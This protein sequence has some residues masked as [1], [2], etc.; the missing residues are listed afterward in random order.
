MSVQFLESVF[1]DSL[2]HPNF[3]N[4]RVLT[5]TD[6]RDEQYASVRRGRYL[7]QAAGE[8]VVYGLN[9]T[10]ATGGNALEITGGLAVCRSGDT[11]HLSGESTTVELVVQEP[12][13]AGTDSPFMVCAPAGSVTLTGVVSTGFYVLA[14]TSASRLSPEL[15]A[16]SGLNGGAPACINRYEEIGVQFK[17]IPLTNADLIAPIGATS[18]LRRSQLAHS[19]FGTNELAAVYTDPLNTPAQYG[20]IDRLRDSRLTDCDVPLAVFQF[21]AGAVDFVDVWSARR[22]CLPGMRPEVFLSDYSP[23]LTEVFTQYAGSRRAVEAMAFLLQFQNHLEDIRTESGVSPPSVAAATYFDYLPAAGYLPIRTKSTHT[24]RFL[25]ASFFGQT[26]EPNELD[27]AYLRSVFHESFYVEPIP[28][29]GAIDVDLY[30][31]PG[32]D[33][34][35]PY[36]IFVRRLP[37]AVEST[38]PTE[39]EEP[40][41]RTGDLQIVVLDE[42][43]DPVPAA[44][45]QAVRATNQR[46]GQVF[47]AKAKGLRET[48]GSGYKSKQIEN[49][50]LETQDRTRTKYGSGSV[51]K[52]EGRDRLAVYEAVEKIVSYIF[53]DVPVGQYTVTAIPIS[54]KYYGVSKAVT[55]RGG[56][57]E[58]E[59]VT[60]REKGIIL[61]GKLPEVHVLPW[62]VIVDDLLID[63]WWKDIWPWEKDFPE[64]DPGYI[65]PAPDDWLRIDDPFV[66]PKIEAVLGSHVDPRVAMD[67]AEIYIRQGYDPATPSGAVDAFVQTK[68]GTR[69][70]MVV[71]AADNALDKPAAVTRTGIPDYDA[72]TFGQLNAYGLGSLE[73]AAS[74]PPGLIGAI[75]GQSESYAG[76]LIQDS[77]STLADDFQNGFMGYPGVTKAVSDAL[78]EE[79]GDKV[80]LANASPGA[81]ADAISGVQG[82][83][84]AAWTG[85]AGRL[86]SDVQ[87]GVPMESFNISAATGMGVDSVAALNEMGI[88]SNNDFLNAVGDD[89]GRAAVRDALGVNDATLNRYLDDTLLNVARGQFLTA[90]QKSIATLE[91]MTPELA[92]ELASKGVY[93]AGTLANSDAAKLA[94]SSRFSEAELQPL[95]EKATDYSYGY[96]TLIEGVTKGEVNGERMTGA[97]YRSVGSIA[98]ADTGALGAVEG[99]T[100]ET[101]VRLN[102]MSNKFMGTVGGGMLVGGF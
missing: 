72:A 42:Q 45:I 34:N 50:L 36:V 37:L 17:L 71:V 74:A 11:L 68:D 23:T 27:P 88:H 25:I 86:L 3:F 51:S 7:G 73:A 102:N 26:I 24:R 97:G 70:P 59:A 65:D 92:T 19:C 35:A 12:L 30:T 28:V 47:T 76:S 1:T 58:Y 14:I 95:V 83:E 52:A 33:D 94:E 48:V 38:E 89:A 5:A 85:F 98:G 39:E 91:G 13:E 84:A 63:P 78:K 75:L 69:Y 8:G 101:A 54:S 57:V 96:S 31:V 82:G 56:A 40:T 55:V 62:G 9:V 4:G 16:H 43:G 2:K 61:P 81:I 90:P 41:Q 99:M 80:G 46:T 21:R 18:T 66:N 67:D 77:R 32:S 64:F 6:L 53:D 87:A 44:L 93:S 29:S 100:P 10:K 20:L 22:P 15:A 60:I 79:F 49:W